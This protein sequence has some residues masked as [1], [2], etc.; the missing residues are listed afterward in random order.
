LYDRFASV[1]RIPLTSPRDLWIFC[2]QLGRI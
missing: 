2:G 1:I